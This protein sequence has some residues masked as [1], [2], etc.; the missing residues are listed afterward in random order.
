M[1][2]PNP[3]GSTTRKG[4]NHPSWPVVVPKFCMLREL[5]MVVY[6]VDFT[7]LFRNRYQDIASNSTF[8]LVACLV[9][10][11]SPLQKTTF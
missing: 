9:S 6:V 10:Q 8:C 5:F 11:A 3:K 7:G 2:A 1:S 4:T